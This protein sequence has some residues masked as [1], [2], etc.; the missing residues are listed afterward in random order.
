MMR[1]RVTGLIGLHAITKPVILFSAE[2]TYLISC[3]K[4]FK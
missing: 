2:G 3:Q 4:R 1:S